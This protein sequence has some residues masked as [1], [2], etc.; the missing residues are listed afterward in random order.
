MGK[1]GDTWRWVETITKT[2]ETDQGVTVIL[3]CRT[4]R[5]KLLIFKGLTV[6]VAEQRED[7]V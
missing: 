1:M 2:G 6:S 5:C 3:R 7:P 4:N